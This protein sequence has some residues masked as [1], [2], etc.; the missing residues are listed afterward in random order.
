MAYARAAVNGEQPVSGTGSEPGWWQASDGRWYPPELHPGHRPR[1]ARIEPGDVTGPPV[2]GPPAAPTADDPPPAV[3]TGGDPE[4]GSRG[5][6]G[7]RPGGR[8]APV[9]S[10][11]LRR[12]RISVAAAV[13]L[14]VLFVVFVVLIVTRNNSSTPSG[15]APQLTRATIGQ[16]VTLGDADHTGIASARVLSISGGAATAGGARPGPGRQL[17]AVDIEICAGPAG[18]V[19]PDVSRFTLV[20]PTGLATPVVGLTTLSPSLWQFDSLSADQ[21]QQGFLSYEAPSS[22]QPTAVRYAGDPTQ[23]VVWRS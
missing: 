16:L 2:P 7:G 21:C 3:G 23:V 17:V 20:L 4:G 13:L 19:G 10:E 1:H 15:A 22:I 18:S 8:P 14:V 12:R 5:G 9:S 11:E 6:P